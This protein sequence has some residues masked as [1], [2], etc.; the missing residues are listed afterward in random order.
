M[1]RYA[2]PWLACAVL[3]MIGIV[4]FPVLHGAFV[5][6]DW[7]SFSDLQGDQWSHYVFRDFN[8]WTVY[9]RPLCV[10]FF[11]LQIKFFNALPGP[12]HAISLALH[13]I[14]TSLVGWL[15]L[16]LGRHVGTEKKRCA[17]TAIFCMLL[18]GTHP[19]LIESVVWIG[20]QFDLIAT[21]FTLCAL[22]ANLSI[23]GRTTRAIVLSVIYLLAACTKESASVLPL[24]I[25]LIDWIFYAHD[26]RSPWGILRTLFQRNLPAYAGMFLAGIAYLAARH[27]ALG[28]VTYPS[29][30]EMNSFLA[31]F[32]ET[33]FIYLKYL[34]IIVWPISEINPLHLVDVTDFGRLSTINL[35][36]DI[37]AIAIV[38]VAFYLA[39]RRAA[40]LGF[41]VLA[42]TF[43]LLPVI[44]ILPISF[45]RSLY[46]ERYATIAIALVCALLPLLKWPSVD[47]AKHGHGRVA[48]LLV[49]VAAIFW[50]IFA[51][52]DIRA[53]TPKWQNDV[54]LWEWA[55][56][57]N[58]DSTQAKDNLLNAYYQAGDLPATQ[59]L[60]DQFLAERVACSSCLLHL[61]GIAMDQN[62]FARAASALDRASTSVLVRK[63][64][65]AQQLYD[66]ELGQL[67]L[68]QH[69][70][71]EAIKILTMAL[72]LKP[73]DTEARRNLSKA[74][75]LLNGADAGP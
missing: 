48:Q 55:L 38:V 39:I 4:Y 21:M 72:Q 63:N 36:T 13:L 52:I 7:P 71:Q 64:V 58:P 43:A 60:A 62:D 18:Y 74:N 51:I 30:F 17:A 75:A 1:S 56:A 10:A 3:A 32:Q 42:V 15:A 20:P 41:L 14:D 8:H 70:Y 25:A 44:R 49:A 45:E 57:T 6:D 34:H 29:T 69:R 47:S 53:I 28:T 65:Q 59:R 9:F 61:A 73:D 54:T 40:S 26:Q 37:A 35:L 67:L 27:T 16:R 12:M 46:H 5:W 50:L 23:A 66:R 68:Q 2:M 33:C 11:A 24:L 22:L 31:H 19:A